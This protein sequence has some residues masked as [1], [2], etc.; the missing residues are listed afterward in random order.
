MN[1]S[2]LNSSGVNPQV[3][4]G[5]EPVAISSIW[6]GSRVYATIGLCVQ[7]AIV[8]TLTAWRGWIW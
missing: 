2:V 3:G 8:T 6:R 7:G 4:E 5:L 1:C